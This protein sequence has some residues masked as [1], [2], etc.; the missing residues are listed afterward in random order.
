MYWWQ[1]YKI[2]IKYPKKDKNGKTERDSNG[3]IVYEEK[4][5][6]DTSQEIQEKIALNKLGEEDTIIEITVTAE[7]QEI[8]KTYKIH[9]KTVTILSLCNIVTVTLSYSIVL[10][11]NH[12]FT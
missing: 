2:K 1:I 3:N 6:T 9:I 7:K 8:Q 12:Y 4:Q 5:I 10:P 11:P